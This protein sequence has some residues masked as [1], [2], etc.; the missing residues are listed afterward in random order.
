MVRAVQGLCMPG[1]LTVGVPYIAEVFVP[2]LGTRAMGLYLAALVVGGLVGRLGVALVTAE[3][4]WRAGL[5]VLALLPLAATIVMRRSLPPDVGGAVDAPRSTG[6]RSRRCCA[7]A[8]WSARRSPARASS[9]ASW[10]LLVRRLPAP[11]PALLALAH[12]GR[13]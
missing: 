6:R 10:R 1:L 3:F 8:R 9:S 4:G 2:R 7:T 13:A 11:G 12:R 5:G